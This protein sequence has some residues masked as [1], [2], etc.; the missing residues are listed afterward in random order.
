MQ[1]G[2]SSH[3]I[4]QSGEHRTCSNM[5]DAFAAIGLSEPLAGVMPVALT[6]LV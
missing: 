1:N 5:S 6:K 4:A 3:R 2:Q